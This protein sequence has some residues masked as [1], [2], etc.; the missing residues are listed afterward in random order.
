MTEN[1]RK[2]GQNLKQIVKVD[3]FT[4]HTETFSEQFSIQHDTMISIIAHDVDNSVLLCSY[5]G[6]GSGV[7]WHSCLVY[8]EYEYCR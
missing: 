5:A 2:Y 3:A 7:G 6:S 8:N 4:T 1:I